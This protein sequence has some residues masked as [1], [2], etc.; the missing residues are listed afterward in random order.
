M[1]FSIKLQ[2]ET[3]TGRCQ[4]STDAIKNIMSAWQRKTICYITSDQTTDTFICAQLFPYEQINETKPTKKA[5]STQYT[6]VMP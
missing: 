1:L 2:M 4:I 5:A 6:T 3:T